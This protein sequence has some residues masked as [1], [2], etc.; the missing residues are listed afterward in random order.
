LP[1]S[2]LMRVRFG[3]VNLPPRIKRGMM[4]ELGEGEVRKVLEWVG[5]PAGKA[6]QVPEA[7]K[8]RSKLKRVPPRKN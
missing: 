2:R 5:L 7:E 4:V 8:R 1:V 6:R 3:I